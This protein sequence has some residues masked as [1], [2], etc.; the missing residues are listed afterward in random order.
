MNNL[1]VTLKTVQDRGIPLDAGH[2]GEV[3]AVILELDLSC[4]EGTEIHGRR[5]RYTFVLEG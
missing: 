5:A 3:R 1:K 4:P 2:S